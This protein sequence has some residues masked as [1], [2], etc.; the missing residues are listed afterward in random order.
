MNDLTQD[1]ETAKGPGHAAVFIW[2]F[3]I[4]S[5]WHYTS[6][7][8]DL[9]NYWFRYDPLVTPL[10]ILS[11]VTAFVAACYPGRTAAL[12]FFSVGQIIAIGLRFP[13]VADHIVMEL[14]LHLAIVLSFCYLAI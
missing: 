7:A 4:A 3:A 2:L 1:R 10:I 11:I 8:Q 14:F 13:F 5:I 6:S 12:L 9:A